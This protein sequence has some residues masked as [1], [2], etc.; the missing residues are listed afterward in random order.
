[1]L[2]ALKHMK[3]HKEGSPLVE[4]AKVWPFELMLQEFIDLPAHC[5]LTSRSFVAYN[6][7]YSLLPITSWT[8]GTTRYRY[9]RIPGH[10]RV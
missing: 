6:G 8:A 4:S 9:T 10:I 3:P 5:A 1:M 7:L 2:G